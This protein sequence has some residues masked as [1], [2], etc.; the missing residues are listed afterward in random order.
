M[1]LV[2]VGGSIVERGRFGVDVMDLLT[3]EV[4]LPGVQGPAPDH[5]D[6]VAVCG[7]AVGE[8]DGGS[9][10]SEYIVLAFGGYSAIEGVVSRRL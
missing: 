2:R 4:L 5:G 7:V 6:G 9:G 3:D 8:S 1:D 10:P